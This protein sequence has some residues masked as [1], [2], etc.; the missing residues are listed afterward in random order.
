MN[1]PVKIVPTADGSPTLYSARYRQHFHSLQGAWQESVY[2]YIQSGLDFLP[3]SLK[4]ISV[5]E[6]GFGT[7]LN[8]LLTLINAQGRRIFYHT[9]DADP[10][11]EE[12]LSQL[13]CP[14]IMDH[15]E[16]SER[17]RA[18]HQAAWGEVVA[19]SPQFSI[20]KD[21][22]RLQD[23][24]APRQFHLIYYDA[25]SFVAQ[26]ELWSEEIFKK[27]YDL[28]YPGAVFVT[29][30]S[31]SDVRRTLAAVGFQVQKIPG[32]PGKREILRAVKVNH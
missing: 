18:I 2:V 10:I 22:V 24:M 29:Y 26:P 27:I 7:G 25:F 1:H 15:P 5:L 21:Q 19:L 20:I 6:M 8:A 11:D 4:E 30:S 31:K 17:F 32:P 23:F 14:Q 13:S 9:L 16:C 3:Q 28:C 12:I